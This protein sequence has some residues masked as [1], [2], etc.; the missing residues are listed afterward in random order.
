MSVINTH[1][2][3]FCEQLVND[4]IGVDAVEEPGHLQSRLTAV[5]STNRLSEGRNLERVHSPFALA[6]FHSTMGRL[7][8][9]ASMACNKHF[10]SFISQTYAPKDPLCIHCVAESFNRTVNI[11]T[12]SG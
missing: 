9:D 5:A 2:S 11:Q 6:A 10:S 4:M 12:T 1:L 3:P 8:E 7:C